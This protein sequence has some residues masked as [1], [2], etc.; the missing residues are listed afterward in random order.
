MNGAVTADQRTKDPHIWMSPPLVK[1]QALTMLNA[2]IRIFPG[3]KEIFSKNY[4]EFA[5]DLDKIDQ[6]LKETLTPVKG[7]TLFVYHPSFGY[8]AE[9]YGLKQRAIETGGKAPGPK[10]LGSIIE[11]VKKRV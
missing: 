6:K 2:L 5:E 4:R 9:R 1:K 11:E 7:S 8:F 10:T 3:K